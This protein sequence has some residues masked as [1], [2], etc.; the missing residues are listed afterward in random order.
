MRS[1]IAAVAEA[2]YSAASVAEIVRRARVSR[3]VFYAHFADKQGCF[4]AAT[5]QSGRLMSSRVVAATCPVTHRGSRS[6]PRKGTLRTDR[7]LSS[8]L[9]SLEEPLQRDR[10]LHPQLFPEQPLAP[11]ELA[12]CLRPIALREVRLDEDAVCCLTQRFQSHRCQGSLDGIGVSARLAEQGSERLQSVQ[13]YL[14]QPFPFVDQPL[15]IPVGE[16]LRA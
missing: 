15:L 4:L 16:Q 12:T 6:P 13:P 7:H 11:M 14:P 9:A 5:G 3:R 1:V 2:G 8:G 10:R